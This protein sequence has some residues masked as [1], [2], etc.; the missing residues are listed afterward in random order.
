MRV[1]ALVVDDEAL[2]RE[3]IR[4]LLA[5]D[6]E[7]EIIGECG[8]G[9]DAIAFIRERRPDLVFLDVQMPEVSGFDVLRALPPEMWPAIIFVTAHD[10]HAVQAFEVHALDY[11]L[12]PFTQARLLAAV[13]RARRHL[14]SPNSGTINQQ[15]AEWLKSAGS[16]SLYL[17]R[18]AVKTGNQTLYVRVKDIEYI[19]SAANYAVLRAAGQNHILRETL[20]HLE[21]KLPPGLFV[22]ISRSIIVNLERIKGIEA[23]PRGE[24]LVLL[25]NGRQLLMTRSVGEIHQKLQYPFER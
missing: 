6:S 13:Q 8:N 18:I 24:D 9:P 5:N 4:K 11:L 7:L 22:R 16:A 25:E 17:D 14:P 1:R 10:K 2:A 19:E 12:K 20:T 3:R 15:L 23:G 21:G